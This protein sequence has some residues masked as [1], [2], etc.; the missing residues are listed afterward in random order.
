MARRVILR[1]SSLQFSLWVGGSLPIR[2]SGCNCFAFHKETKLESKIVLV[3]FGMWFM[4]GQQD[5]ELT[6]KT[7]TSHQ[8]S[9]LPVSLRPAHHLPLRWYLRYRLR[10]DRS[11]QL[12]AEPF[13]FFSRSIRRDPTG[14]ISGDQPN[15]RSLRCCST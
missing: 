6:L 1:M 8:P 12:C 5:T 7:I 9:G 13:R 3:G 14:E 10:D 11:R 15:S 4:G 2:S